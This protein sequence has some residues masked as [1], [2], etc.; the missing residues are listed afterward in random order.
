MKMG[1]KITYIVILLLLFGIGYFSGFNHWF[2]AESYDTELLHKDSLQIDSIAKL[3]TLISKQQNEISILST[4]V[5]SVNT[6]YQRQLDS[7]ANKPLS[8]IEVI[9]KQYVPS[10]NDSIRM[11]QI[12]RLTVKYNSAQATILLLNQLISQ[13]N[14]VNYNLQKENKLLLLR[15]NYLK[16]RL[17]EVNKQMQ[18]SKKHCKKKMTGGLIIFSLVLFGI[19][20]IN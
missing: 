10:D 3:N 7:L 20:V 14:K 5:D 8:E 12:A 16:K 9:A 1:R 11:L 19:V 18:V 17:E 4:K 2:I 6:F 13:N 15:S